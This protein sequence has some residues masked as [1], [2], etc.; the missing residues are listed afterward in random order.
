MNLEEFLLRQGERIIPSG[1]EKRLERDHSV[2]IRGSLWYD[3]AA[4]QGGGAI[5]FVQNFYGVSYPEAVTRLLG[6]ERGQVYPSFKNEKQP[7]EFT[8]PPAAPN[9]RRVFAYL[10]K[11]RGI[12]RDVLSEFT[13]SKLVYED[14]RCHNAVFVGYDEHGIARHAHKRSTGSGPGSFRQTVEG[15]D[16]HYAFHWQGED[17][18]LYVFEAP[19]DLLSYITLHP[20]VWRLHSYTALFGTSSKPVLGMLD[21]SPQ[22]R[23]VHLCLDSDK[24]GQT[25]SRRIASLL[26]RKRIAA[27]ILVPSRKDWNEDLLAQ[28]E[29]KSAAQNLCPGYSR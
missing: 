12:S 5:S 13:H 24:A 23:R 16:F 26:E 11:T 22:L 25:A 29:G 27:G 3:H 2:T 4:E 17:E 6:G 7:A 9:M 10:V 19:I 28:R 15:S 8:L 14:A 1:R 20:D 18:H 21:R